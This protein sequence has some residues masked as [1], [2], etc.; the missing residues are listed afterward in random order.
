LKRGDLFELVRHAVRSRDRGALTPSATPLATFDALQRARAAGVR[1]VGISLDGADAATHD[2]F[3]GWEGSF[4]RT[5]GMLDAARRL[6]MAV[7]VN[8]TITRRNVHQVD[9]NCRAALRAGHRHVAAFF[10]VPSGDGRRTANRAARVRGGVRTPMAPCQYAAFC[11]EDHGG[12][13]LTAGSCCN[14]RR[15]WPVPEGA[16]DSS[17]PARSTA[18]RWA[19]AT[20][21]VSCSSVTRRDLPG[22][23]PA[24]VLRAVSACS[25]VEVYQHHPTFPRAARPGRIQGPLR[26]C[27]Y[28]QVAAGAVHGRMR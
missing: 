22:G 6:G 15:P 9:A 2:A 14:R 12:P 5:L 23:I 17:C 27:E 24:A 20:A 19:S 13:A 4:Q 28:R 26:I 7:Q 18:R 8:T 3:R 11:R 10:L 1:S 16:R 21:R 25:V